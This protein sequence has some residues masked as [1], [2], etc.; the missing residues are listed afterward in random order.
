MNNK[1]TAIFVSMAA[2]AALFVVTAPVFAHHGTAAF[3]TSKLVTVKGN[4]TDFVFS[5]PHVQVYF[6]VTNDKGEKEAWQGELTA[7]NKLIRA[8]WNKRTLKPGD[9]VTIS[10]FQVKSGQHTLWIRKLIG[11]E[12]EPLQLFED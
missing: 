3:D 9:A 12:G 11:P 10:G 5:N 1:K 4:I 6:E 8:G 7:P 2:I